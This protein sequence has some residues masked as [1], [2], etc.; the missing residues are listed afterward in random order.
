MELALI[1]N[2]LKWEGVSVRAEQWQRVTDKVI[3]IEQ[4]YAVNPSENTRP[5]RVDCIGS[6]QKTRINA[7]F[8][9]ESY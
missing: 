4:A 2:A 3:N 6:T 8:L 1:E 9:M 5:T 7:M